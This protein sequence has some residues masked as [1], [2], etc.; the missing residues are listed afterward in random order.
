MTREEILQAASMPASSPS[1]PFGPYRFF[2]REYFIISYRT[3]AEAI[4]RYLPEPLEPADDPIVHYEWI[5]MPDS[6]GFGDYTESGIVLPAKFEGQAVGFVNQMFLDDL[7]PIVA[8]REIW[9]FPKEYAHVGLEVRK[10]T[11]TGILEYAGERVATG[12]MAYKTRECDR[13]EIRQS[14]A[15]PQVLLKMIPHVDGSPAIAQL[16]AIN[17]EDIEIKGAWDARAALH[18]L[19]H[20][21]AEVAQ[22]P[23]REVIKGTHFITNLTL[24]YGRVIHD[25]LNE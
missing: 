8:G 6:Q 18:L 12:T 24:P 22:F 9:G 25:Y 13:E 3:D 5:R 10:D 20:A 4:N 7:P 1:Y 19:P 23:V 15:K 16:V 2:D 11:L 17:L 21:H 14:L